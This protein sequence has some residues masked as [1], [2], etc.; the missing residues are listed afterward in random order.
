MDFFDI[1]LKDSL[2]DGTPPEAVQ[3]SLI[4]RL[5]AL[6]LALVNKPP[7]RCFEVI[8][9]PE[10]EAITISVSTSEGLETIKVFSI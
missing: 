2:S 7:A 3:A 10:N 1:Y 4:A 9:E 5:Q 6:N 8:N